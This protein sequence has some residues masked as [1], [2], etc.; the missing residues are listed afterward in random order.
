MAR[1]TG[2]KQLYALVPGIDVAWNYADL[3]QRISTML[4][5]C[6]IFIYS[7]QRMELQSIKKFHRQIL[8]RTHVP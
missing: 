6:G 4:R 8:I 1:L 2:C 5:F 3:L 7:I